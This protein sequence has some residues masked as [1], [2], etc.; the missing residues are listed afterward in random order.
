MGY[1]CFALVVMTTLI[2]L[3]ANAAE[4]ISEKDRWVVAEKISTISEG[5][6]TMI[7][8]TTRWESVVLNG[9]T[10]SYVFTLLQITKEEAPDDAG[11]LIY[12]QTLN[13]YCTAGGFVSHL[14][15]YEVDLSIYFR[16]AEGNT[17]A[18]SMI[19]HGDCPEEVK[20][21]TIISEPKLG[22]TIAV[23]PEWLSLSERLFADAIEIWPA[24][25]NPSERLLGKWQNDEAPVIYQFL[26]NGDAHR[27]EDNKVTL[28]NY[29]V[30]DINRERRMMLLKINENTD[31]GYDL[32]I[33]FY[34][35]D[36]EARVAIVKD[37]DKTFEKW[38]YA[39]RPDLIAIAKQYAYGKK[40]WISRSQL[41]E[42]DEY[43]RLDDRERSSTRENWK[44][45]FGNN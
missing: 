42:S 2:Q 26:A 44:E 5:L 19:N 6:P 20:E 8:K 13:G 23:D 43:K 34:L 27:I 25:D 14:R 15:D 31:S 38:T 30:A 33:Q 40:P 45:L 29:S 10:V 17:L 11:F 22:D 37:G 16:D 41:L 12:R 4:A 36:Q 28:L 1:R 24:A 3:Y 9:T 7:D 18:S 32:Y 21:D 39:G 35:V